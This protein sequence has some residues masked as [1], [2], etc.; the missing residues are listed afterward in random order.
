MPLSNLNRAI[1]LTFYEYLLVT[2]PVGLYIAIEATHEKKWNMLWTSPKWSVAT[3][4]LLFQGLTLYVRFLNSSGGKVSPYAIGV[5]G[6]IG[7]G[8]IIIA[9]LNAWMSLDPS[10]NSKLAIG[11][12]LIVVMASS[13]L[14]FVF[15]SAARLYQL[16]RGSADA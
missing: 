13:G 1:L 8:L 3:I 10:E 5:G 12:R 9:V 14:F 15:V 16:K 2:F 11:V 7:L 4:F 6:I